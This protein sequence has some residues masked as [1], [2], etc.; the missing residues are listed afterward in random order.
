MT[1]LLL[2]KG[3]PTGDSYFSFKCFQNHTKTKLF[4]RVRFYDIFFSLWWPLLFV[5]DLSV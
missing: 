4:Q 3:N 2:S 5:I 1:L